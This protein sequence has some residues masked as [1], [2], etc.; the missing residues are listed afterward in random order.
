MRTENTP[1]LSS[2]PAAQQWLENFDTSDRDTAVLLLN[3][4]MLVGASEFALRINELLNAIPRWS[5]KYNNWLAIYAEREIAKDGHVVL[6]FFPDT[7]VGRA[8]GPGIPPVEVDPKKQDVGSEGVVATLVAKYCK[9]AKSRALSHPGPDALRDRRAQTIVIV[10]DFVGSGRRVSEMLDAFAKVASIQS[11]ISYHLLNFHVVCYSGTEHGIDVVKRHSTGPAV[12]VHIACPVVEE[13]FE[14]S[15]LGAVKKLCKAYPQKKNKFPF[16]F[17]DTGSL[18]AFSHGIPNNAPALL[19]SRTGGW[20]PLF[21]NRSTFEVRLDA[22]ASAK[23][24][25]A[26]RSD[27]VLKLRSARRVLHSDGDNERLGVFSIMDVIRQGVRT[28]VRISAQ[29]G[30]SMGEV[31]AALKLLRQAHWISPNNGLTQA[32]RRELR[33]IRRVSSMNDEIAYPLST[34]YFPTQLRGA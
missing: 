29:T 6:P 34:P 4:L 13:V 32:G 5:D 20:T 23:D 19:H 28:P 16:G 12:S 26:R 22:Y 8:T 24:Q 31:E 33:S 7:G 11:W 9:P 21:E 10:S 17:R 25:L 1:Q 30:S 15:T 14:G 3:T 2:S 27:H 18:I